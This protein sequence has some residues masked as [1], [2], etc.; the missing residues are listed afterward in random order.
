MHPSRVGLRSGVLV[1]L[2]LFLSTAAIAQPKAKAAP[3]QLPPGT[4][5]FPP[6]LASAIEARIREQLEGRLVGGLS[7]GVVRGDLAWTAGFG[8][9][10]VEQR[11]RATPRTT[12]RT[13]SIGKCFTAMAVLQLVEAGTVSLDDDIRKWVPAFPAKPWPVTVRQLLG[14][15]GGVSHYRDLAKD[16]RSTK[17]M[18]TSEAIAVFKD[19]PLV[20]EPGTEYTYTTYGYN[21]LGA[22]VE[23]ASGMPYGKYLQQKVFA[24]AGMK[25]AALDDFRTRDAW[26]AV[27]YRPVSGT[28]ARSHRLD[29][30]SRFGGG[31]TRASVVDLLAFGRAVMAS[32]LVKPET[33]RLMQVPMETKD[34]RLTDYGMGFAT[35]PLRGHYLVAHAGGQPET[36]TFLLLIPA[37]RLAIALA[38]NVE[39][40]GELLRDLYGSLVELLLDGGS[41]RRPVHAVDPADEV[42][43]EGLYR[44]FSYGRAYY[45]FHRA[46]FSAPPEPGDLP[47]AFAETSRL[48]S[49][50]T[51]TAGAPAALKAV[52]QAHQALAGRLFIRVGTQM[53]ERIA[54]ALGPEALSRYPA[55]GALAFF[56][57]YLHA[58]ERVRCPEELQFSPALRADIARLAGPWR[59]ANAP[60][61]RTVSLRTVPE[62]AQALELIQATLQGAPVHPDYAE[63]ALAIAQSPKTPPE[64]GLRLLDWAVKTHPGSIPA[65]LARADAFLQAGDNEAAELLY[66]RTL[67]R[68]MGPELLSPEKFLARA[69]RHPLGLEL[70]DIAVE[71]HPNSVAL[72]QALAARE[73]EAGNLG[74]AQAAME[75]VME[76]T[77]P[78]AP[79]QGTVTP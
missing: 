58:C 26:H 5:A 9:R 33:T 31:G 23:S 70:L 42:L 28:L 14:H 62:R 11:L 52:K 25:N 34:G 64:E 69:K 65:L 1:A 37:E 38:M 54:T 24:P 41:R 17:R 43:H 13:A 48:L 68:P 73:Q 51:I 71:L 8:F 22:L 32:T 72:W 3:A 12:Y 10:D 66:R 18:S 77:P 20:V 53:A 63:E 15:L 35:Y 75:R 61:L 19:W 50:E 79:V 6:E 30:S 49:R 39:D 4:Q 27:G 74:A 59:K 7:V 55:E 56:E 40:Q 76:L 36:S 47:S 21:L 67:E 29:V 78:P 44:I 46:G 60:E 2:A 57:D 16:N 45:T